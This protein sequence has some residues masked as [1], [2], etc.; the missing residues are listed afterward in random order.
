MSTGHVAD[1]GQGVC[2]CVH[3]GDG[4]RNRQSE[5]GKGAY[6]LLL[7]WERNLSTF[8]MSTRLQNEYPAIGS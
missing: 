8:P 1:S 4:R 2:V 5:G 7:P 3:V 6:M